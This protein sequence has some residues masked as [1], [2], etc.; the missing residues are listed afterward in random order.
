[1][2]IDIKDFYLNTPMERFKYMKLK[3]SDLPKYF[4]TLYNLVSKV[5]KNGFIYLE[6]RRSMY[7]LPQAGIL[8]QHLLEKQLNNKGYS[9]DSL[10]PGL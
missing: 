8:D 6:I 10:V 9:Q 4:V 5:D 1:M 3:L 2:T 7:G